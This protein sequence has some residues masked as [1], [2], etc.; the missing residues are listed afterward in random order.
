MAK[1]AAEKLQ[2][3]KVALLQDVRWICWNFAV[4]WKPQEIGCI[5]AKSKYNTGDQDFQHSLSI[6]FTNNNTLSNFTESA[7]NKASK[8][9]WNYNL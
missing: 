9:V 1:Y 3:K 8:T 2:A 6:K 7:Y 4:L 5:V